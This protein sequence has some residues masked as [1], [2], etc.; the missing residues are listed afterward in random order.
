M[1]DTYQKVNEISDENVLLPTCASLVEVNC[2]YDDVFFGDQ[3]TIP[4]IIKSRPTKLKKETQKH[5]KNVE[6]LT[7]FKKKPGKFVQK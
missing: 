1:Q 6:E 5:N 7:S 2:S 3:A 4:K